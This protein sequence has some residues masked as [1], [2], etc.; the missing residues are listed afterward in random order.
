MG[1]PGYQNVDQTDFHY[2]S[3]K[4][5]FEMRVANKI[6][7]TI[8]FLSPVTPVDLMRQ[9][10]VFSYLDVSVRSIDGKQHDVQLYSDISAG[11]PTNQRDLISLMLYR[12]GFWRGRCRR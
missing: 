11:K 1:A 3:T 6:A 10:L 7:M 9:S 4:S 12:M 2:T 8:T 5:I